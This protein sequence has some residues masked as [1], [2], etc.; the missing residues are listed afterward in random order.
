M[1]DSVPAPQSILFINVSRIGDTLLATPALRAVAHAWPDAA[2][3]FLGHPHRSEVVCNLPFV[4]RVGA[5][6]KRRAQWKGWLSGE[7][8]D[9]AIVLGFDRALVEYALRVANRV[10][11]FAQGHPALDRRLYRAVPRP[12]FQA[13]HSA[14]IPLL[15][16]RA[17]GVP[18]AGMRLAYSVTVSE[19]AA[20]SRLLSEHG[21]A[22][23][24]PLIGLQMS[25]FPT[26][27][28]RNWPLERFNELALRITSHAPHAHLLLLGGA[29]DRR[30]NATI[31]ER[32]P[33]RATDLAGTLSLRQSAAVMSKL[34]LYIGVDT[35]P[36]HIMGALEG[37]MVALYHCYSPSRLLRPL[38]RQN[39]YAVDHPRGE[40]CSPETPMGEM[41]VDMV[42]IKV[43]EALGRQ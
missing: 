27:A 1:P 35:G 32:L 25:S 4:S 21:I 17:L 9:I 5:I 41:S 23:K 11:A 20:A 39:F 29:A 6:T 24:H 13:L 14:E 37:P 28:Y 26:K 31:V 3:V 8:H 42:W 16:T 15:L 2:L 18:D 36:T 33:G 22:G 40:G 43:R 10:V 30:S 7:R 34:D 19:A 12:G 38:E